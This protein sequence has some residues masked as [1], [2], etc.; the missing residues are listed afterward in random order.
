MNEYTY[1]DTKEE[2]R[3]FAG[4]WGLRKDWHEPDEQGVEA[5][6]IGTELDNA[7]GANGHDKRQTST[8]RVPYSAFSDAWEG[9]EMRVVL[10]VANGD[11]TEE[12]A[13]V[14]LASLLAWA[15]S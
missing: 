8:W 1:I 9:H 3:A 12:R 5:R 13:I 4:R 6:V 2:L 14:N 7:F 15:A 10:R 11:Q